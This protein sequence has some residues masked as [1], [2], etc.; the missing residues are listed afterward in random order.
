MIRRD[1]CFGQAILFQCL[2]HGRFDGR[3]LALVV[4]RPLCRCYARRFDCADRYFAA[5]PGDPDR[6]GRLVSLVNI[7]GPVGIDVDRDVAV[8]KNI[9]E[10]VVK[11]ERRRHHGHPFVGPAGNNGKCRG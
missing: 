2:R 4:H 1:T 3:M 5:V 10:R 9:S 7:I 6:L 8:L 11:G